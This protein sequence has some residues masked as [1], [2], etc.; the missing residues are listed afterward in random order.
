M[1]AFETIDPATSACFV[2]VRRE[3]LAAALGHDLRIEV[4]RHSLGPGPGSDFTAEFD[5]S[6]LRVVGALDSAGTVRPGVLSAKDCATVESSIRD[7]VLD[8]RRHPVVRFEG[9][10]IDV[11]ASGL[12]VQ[13]ELELNGVRRPLTAPVASEAGRYVVRVTLH[14]PDWGITPFR[15]MLGALRVQADV[16]VELSVARRG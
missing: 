16:V 12:S 15:G 4:T 11:G 5:A 10:T 9:R 8:V 13:G 2:T 1:S 7:K 6:S 14:Q 3:G